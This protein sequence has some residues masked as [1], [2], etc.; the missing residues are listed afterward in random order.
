M[1]KPIS[2]YALHKRIGNQTIHTTKGKYVEVLINS[3]LWKCKLVFTNNGSDFHLE[4][5]EKSVDICS[6]FSHDANG[7]DCCYGTKEIDPCSC[8]GDKNK[9]NF[10]KMR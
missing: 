10:Y 6:C 4:P 1:N 3:E 8:N 2:W 9:C 7:R 5:V